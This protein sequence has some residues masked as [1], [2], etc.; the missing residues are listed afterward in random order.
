MFSIVLWTVMFLLFFI[1]VR[2]VSGQ[3]HSQDVMI[4]KEAVEEKEKNSSS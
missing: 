3:L 4:E 2:F 1:V